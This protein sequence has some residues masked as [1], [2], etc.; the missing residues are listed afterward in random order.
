M[1]IYSDQELNVLYIEGV[2]QGPVASYQ[3]TAKGDLI[4]AFR[5]D[6]GVYDFVNQPFYAIQNRSGISLMSLAETMIY[7]Q[8]LT[9]P[10]FPLRF[11]V[12]YP[13]TMVGRDV[14]LDQQFIDST[15]YNIDGGNS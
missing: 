6:Q 2:S 11:S 10:A 12:S 13:L 14:E 3:F 15:I 4:S 5:P 7:L 9:V 1:K 8:S